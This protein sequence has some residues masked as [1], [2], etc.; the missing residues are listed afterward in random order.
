MYPHL[1]SIP[2]FVIAAVVGALVASTLAAGFKNPLITLCAGA[3][4]ASAGMGLSFT[5]EWGQGSIPVQSYGTMILVGFVFAVW[6]AAR[7]SPQLGIEPHHCLDIGVYGVFVGLGGSRVFDILMNWNDFNPF[8]AG[9]FDVARVADMFKLWKGGL[10]FYGAF[11]AVIPYGFLYCRRNK[12][13]GLPFIDLLIMSVVTGLA[14]GRIGCF[15]N[16]CC[17]GKTCSLPWAVKFPARLP[18]GDSAAHAWHAA[19]GWIA[20]SAPYSLPVHP[21]QIY[22]SIAAALTAAFLYA[23]WPRRKYDGQI[24]SLAMIMVGATRFFEELLRD[25]EGAVFPSICGW[26]T[27]A[28]WVALFII[29][30]GFGLMFYY[31]N[32]ATNFRSVLA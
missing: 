20:A 17:F 23:Y 8:H 6:I 10:V 11:L 19:N 1:F 5:Q 12:L 26:M 18:P 21:T 25:D 3:L 13:P 28:Q 31:R 15:L 32:R 2:I 27:I 4:G 9:G 24:L 30:L 14:F 7:R 29:A 22:A 16:G